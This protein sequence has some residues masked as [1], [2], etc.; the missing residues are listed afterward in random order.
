MKTGFTNPISPTRL[1]PAARMRAVDRRAIDEIGIPGIVLMEQAGRGAARMIREAGWLEGADSEVLLLAGKGNNGGDAFVVAR[2][3]ALTGQ[4][5]RVVLLA[6]RDRIRGDARTNLEIYRRLG[7]ELH[8]ITSL[9]EWRAGDFLSPA[10]VV[11]DGLLG[12]GLNSEVRGLFAAVIADLNRFTG[13]ILA[14]DIPSGLDADRGR[15][16]G[17]AV[18]ATATATFA[19]S[20]PGLHLYPGR[21]YAGRIEIIDIG[22]PR[23]WAA[24]EENAAELLEAGF[25]RTLL[26]PEPAADSHKGRRGHLLVCAGR[27]GFTGAG[28]L[29]AGAGLRAGAGLVTLALPESA[30]ARIEG[31]NP[32]LMLRYLPEA[33]D[34]SPA[35]PAA[36]E[37][38]KLLAGKQALAVGPGFGLGESAAALLEKLLQQSSLAKVV[39]ADA[40]TL[41]A[42]APGM[43]PEN[44][45]SLILTPHP[46]EAARLL[47]CESAEIQADRPAA[48]RELARRYRAWVVLKGAGSLIAAPDGALSINT[49]GNPLLATAGSGDLLCGIIGAF[50][51][52]GAKPGPALKAAVF[53]HGRAADRLQQ[54][55]AGEGV[56]A[57]E[58]Q[59]EIPNALAAL[60]TGDGT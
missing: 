50:L 27:A 12:T 53:L 38:K 48:A 34:G 49:S 60:R 44:P 33:A 51:A 8:E 9:A 5:V 11:V 37:L 58:I 57:L 56:T 52:R 42:A 19:F 3:L 21:D 32:S 17:I 26:P 6:A 41:L 18:K 59:R 23:T 28:L 4:K 46:G 39:D 43:L 36:A 20:K 29:A 14:L 25:C 22:I 54:Q 1:L 16:L 24:T 47:G 31:R 30:A 13:P 55:G 10:Q 7:G 2:V 35:P 45:G 40:L 15:P